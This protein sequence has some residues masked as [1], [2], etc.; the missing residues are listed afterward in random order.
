[1]YVQEAIILA[2]G[3][4]TRL[5]GVVDDVPKVMAPVNGKPFLEYLLDYLENNVIEHVVLSVGYKY[6]VIQEHFKDKY[7]SIKIDYAIEDKPLG[8]GGGIQKA[9]E[10]IN[11]TKSL[12][13]NGDTMFQVN[14]SRINEFHFSQSAR[15]TI[16]LRQVE[17]VT[18]YGSVETNYNNRIIHFNEKGEQF[19]PGKING[20][21]Y[22]IN[23]SFFTAKNFPEKFSLEKD[24]FEK[25]YLT[26]PFHGI[27]CKQYFIDIG[28]PEDYQKA[29]NDFKLFGY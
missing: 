8:T 25:L 29:N 15:F 22:L 1:M 5:K 28:I 2:G 23:K 21:V 19:G 24:V 3:L 7:K 18:R 13:L 11:G 16:V 26:Q 10:F 9:F 6:E 20:G 17:D 4:G 27:V 14:L 12:V